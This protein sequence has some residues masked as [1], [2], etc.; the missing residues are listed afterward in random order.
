VFRQPAPHQTLLL[1]VF[2]EEGWWAGPVDDPLPRAAFEQDGD[3]RQRLH[4][5]IKNLNRSLPPHTIRF[6]GDGTGQGVCW[7]YAC[8]P[9]QR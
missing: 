3:A 5:T 4:E 1:A 6:H 7:A 9:G 8:R 2:R